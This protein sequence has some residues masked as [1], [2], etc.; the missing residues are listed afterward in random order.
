MPYIGGKMHRKWR[1]VCVIYLSF[2][3]A[4]FLPVGVVLGKIGPTSRRAISVLFFLA[5]FHLKPH[6]ISSSTSLVFCPSQ[7]FW[8]FVIPTCRQGLHSTC[9]YVP[10]TVNSSTFSHNLP[11]F[12]VNIP[13]PWTISPPTPSLSQFHCNLISS[14]APSPFHLRP[15]TVS[16]NSPSQP[17]PK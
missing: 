14:P 10:Q 15:N 6:W 5:V 13:E 9:P 1:H 12:P 3:Y 16:A 11:L 17:I 2:C 8:W 7:L 4:N